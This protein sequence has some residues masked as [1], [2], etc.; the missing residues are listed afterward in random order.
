MNTTATVSADGI[1]KLADLVDDIV[2]NALGAECVAIGA[3]ISHVTAAASRAVA[4]TLE[5]DELTVIDASNIDKIV[6]ETIAWIGEESHFA[7]E[8]ALTAWAA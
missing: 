8:E 5:L 4:W 6:N 2:D 7:L 1:A 3:N